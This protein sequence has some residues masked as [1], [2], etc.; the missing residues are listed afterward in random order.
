PEPSPSAAE[1]LARAPIAVVAI[2]LE[3]TAALAEALRRAVGRILRTQPGARLA[4]ITV[5]KTPRIAIES[6]AGEEGQSARRSHLVELK[7]WARPLGI[8]PHRVTYHVL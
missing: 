6:H 8:P 4:C 2:D 1:Q 3:A 5:L 7:D